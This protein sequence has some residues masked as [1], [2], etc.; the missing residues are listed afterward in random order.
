MS[1][2]TPGILLSAGRLTFAFP[3]LFCWSLLFPPFFAIVPV[4][5]FPFHCLYRP[6]IF[7][8]A[9]L[10]VSV[11]ISLPLSPA[12]LFFCIFPRY[13]CLPHFFYHCPCPLSFFS[14]IPAAPF[15]VSF[16]VIPAPSPT[17][18]SILLTA[19]ADNFVIIL[20]ITVVLSVAVFPGLII[21]ASFAVL[22]PC[23]C[24]PGLFGPAAF[25]GFYPAIP[26]VPPWFYGLS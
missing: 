11:V 25:P 16:V 1:L 3:L 20:V 22:F 14:V 4:I 17:V 2:T 9:F 6:V 5:A 19:P 21:T 13:P 26:P 24:C 8:A 15:I 10:A 18:V 12:S 7:P 23:R